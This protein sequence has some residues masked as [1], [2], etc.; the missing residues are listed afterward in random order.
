MTF[1]ITTRAIQGRLL[2]RPSKELN[3][4]ILGILGRALTLYPV[5]L[6]LVVVASNHIHLI[7]TTENA[8]LLSDFMRYFNG[9]LAREAG[10]LH[11]WREK[12]WGRRYY[13]LSILDETKLLERAQYLLSH[14]CKEGLVLRPKDWPG[15]NCVEALTRGKKLSGTWY[16]RTRE[17]EANRER[18]D[19]SAKQFPTRYEV[20]L[21]PLPCYAD[22][23]P[24]QQRANYRAMVKDI[25][26]ATRK[27]FE[28]AGRR[29]LGVQGVLRQS[30]HKRPKN[31]K[32]SPA[33]LCHSSDF[34]EWIRYRDDYRW[35]VGQY[36]EASKKMRAGDLT[37]KFP[38]NCF[39][40]QL[41]FCGP[42]PPS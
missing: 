8:K 27:R 15:V 4:I 31:V 7:I 38:E 17:Y 12:F 20:S 33:P 24:A 25:E 10:K 35:F 41:A 1:E 30:P 23:S 40:P 6:H 29:V 32:R 39:P 3:D 37:V 14:G 9:N 11:Q 18:F 22:L 21:S 28:Q 42:S 34:E 13:A 26:T 5:L 2:L 16:D 36:R 19:F